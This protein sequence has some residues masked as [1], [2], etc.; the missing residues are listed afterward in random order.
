MDLVQKNQTAELS[1]LK[2]LVVT[3]KWTS[4]VDFD[5]AALYVPKS[6]EHGLIYFGNKGTLNEFPF[7][8]LDQDS[9]V[10]DSGGDNEENL[11]ITKLDEM[12]KIYLICWDW[13]SIQ[14]GTSARFVDSDLNITLTSDTGE[15]NRVCLDDPGIGNILV[16]AEIKVSPIGATLINLNKIGTLKNLKDSNQILEIINS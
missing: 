2:K 15:V 9:G 8:G 10:G 12:S 16:M 4:A 13:G 7:I 6:G 1:S 5:L 14:S 3:M 11:R